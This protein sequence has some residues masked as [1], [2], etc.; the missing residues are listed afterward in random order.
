MTGGFVQG[1][2]YLNCKGVVVKK[3]LKILRLQRKLEVRC[4]KDIGKICSVQGGN[5]KPKAPGLQVVLVL[6][7]AGILRDALV[8]MASFFS[9]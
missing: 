9:R 3:M 5:L 1:R 8:P 2:F 7:S 6:L 4:A